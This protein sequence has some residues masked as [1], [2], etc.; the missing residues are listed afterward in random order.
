MNELNTFRVT[1]NFISWFFRQKRPLSVII[2]DMAEDKEPISVGYSNLSP[3]ASGWACE[4]LQ[5][6]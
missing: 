2:A 1:F 3:V 4:S 6:K 5:R